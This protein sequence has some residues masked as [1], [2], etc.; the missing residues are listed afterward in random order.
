MLSFLY[1]VNK[2]VLFLFFFVV[3]NENQNPVLYD[4]A[5]TAEKKPPCGPQ[6]SRVVILL[7][8]TEPYPKTSRQ[9]PAILKAAFLQL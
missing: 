4:F 5:K 6:G 3:F 7:L 8:L 2:N 1:F 9:K